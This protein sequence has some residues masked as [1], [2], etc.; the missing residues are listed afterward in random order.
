MS[1]KE[2]VGRKKWLI[3]LKMVINMNET[4][5]CTIEQA[6]EFLSASAPIKFSTAGD[7]GERYEHVSRVLH[8]VVPV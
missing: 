2:D 8:G 4:Q 5:L 3:I 6:E 7:D 1:L